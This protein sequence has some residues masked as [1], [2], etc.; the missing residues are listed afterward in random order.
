MCVRHGMTRMMDLQNKYWSSVAKFSRAA[1]L[2][3]FLE[4][5]EDLIKKNMH[6]FIDTFIIM[7][8]VGEASAVIHVARA[9][10]A[11]KKHLM[12][13]VVASAT[14]KKQLSELVL[15]E[16]YENEKTRQNK[17]LFNPVQ[18]FV[19]VV[20]GNH[21]RRLKW[22]DRVNDWES[23]D[24]QTINMCLEG[25]ELRKCYFATWCSWHR[26]KQAGSGWRGEWS[27]QAATQ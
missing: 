27:I 6:S 18:R 9:W 23:K 20:T 26:L 7:G 12:Q 2:L 14:Q 16:V 10:V 1:R 11:W 5:E 22:R 8:N 13:D 4:D 24:D 21:F 15:Q 25:S 3:H 17:Q 19:L